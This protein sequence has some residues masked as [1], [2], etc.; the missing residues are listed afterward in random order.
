LALGAA[1]FLGETC[2][3]C[4]TIAAVPAVLPSLM[5]GY[6]FLNV[7]WSLIFKLFGWSLSM[8]NHIYRLWRRMPQPNDV[9]YVMDYVIW[10]SFLAAPL[11][12]FGGCTSS[13]TRPLATLVCLSNGKWA[14]ALKDANNISPASDARPSYFAH[15]TRHALL[16]W[17]ASFAFDHLVLGSK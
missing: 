9:R 5:G 8:T 13:Y 15:S 4:R 1:V 17:R 10:F 16:F 7:G 12:F 3:S 11:Y 14:T 6:P 2:H